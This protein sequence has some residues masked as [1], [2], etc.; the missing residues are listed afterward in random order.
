[1][2][3]V[4]DYVPYDM[5]FSIMETG[6]CTLLTVHNRIR[7]IRSFETIRLCGIKYVNN[8]LVF[9][10]TPGGVDVEVFKI[11]PSKL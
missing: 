3:M 2:N 1:M 8:G 10:L 5:S 9:F 11:Q 7:R 6:N 4:N